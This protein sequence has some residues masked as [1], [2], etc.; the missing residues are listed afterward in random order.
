[1]PCPPPFGWSYA[2]LLIA[3]NRE[4]ET[5]DWN[6]VTQVLDA[7]ANQPEKSRPTRV[8]LAVLRAEVGAASNDYVAAQRQL[9]QVDENKNTRPAAVWV[10][11]AGLELQRGKVDSA[12]AILDEASKH[13]G[14]RVELRLARARLWARRGGP[15]AAK[16]LARLA[17]A[18]D[19]FSEI[20][21]LRLLRVLADAY[22]E[23]G[24]DAGAM[25]LLRK[26][27]DRRESDL[28][29]RFALFE[30]AVRTSNAPAMRR[31]TDAIR[32]IEGEPEGTIWRYCVAVQRIWQAE[33]GDKS[34]LG[35]AANLLKMVGDRRPGWARVPLAQAQVDDLQGQPD[36]AVAGYKRAVLLGESRPAVIK[37]LVRILTA[38]GEHLAAE[39][40]IRKLRARSGNQL[41]GLEA[42]GSRGGAV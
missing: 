23:T 9:E 29:S 27:A 30:L 34:G 5:A 28:G 16:A 21:H 37:Q 39:H 15:G 26:V 24:D 25:R 32:N 7:A 40:M 31:F 8:T 1:M 2:Q 14:D 12:E 10:G 19:R 41:I 4:A 11:L 36:A 20:D 35:E 18:T 13:L 38:R 22:T 3:R 17:E 33:H 6:Q 42:L